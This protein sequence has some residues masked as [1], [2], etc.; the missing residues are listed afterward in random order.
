MV[1]MKDQSE[2]NEQQAITQ[3]P[4]EVIAANETR[5]VTPKKKSKKWW[6]FGGG[7]LLLVVVIMAL[8]I[9]KP[10]TPAPAEVIQ[11]PPTVMPK[12]TEMQ[13]ELVR[14]RALVK[15]AN[16]ESDPF[17]PPQVDMQVEF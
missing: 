6:L 14:I 3:P 5:S 8:I 17:P 15:Q 9:S 12:N 13:E 11:V 7:V 10:K 2:F 16:P 4:P 1:N